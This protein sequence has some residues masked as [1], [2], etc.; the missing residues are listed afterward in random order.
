MKN[1]SLFERL[2]KQ[3][4]SE[5][6]TGGAGVGGTVT[7]LV[8]NGDTYAPGN[9]IIPTSLFGGKMFRRVK[10]ICKKKKGRSKKKK[11]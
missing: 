9:A 4:L 11:R 3:H 10:P 2:F 1:P 7:D 8:G 5:N 6:T